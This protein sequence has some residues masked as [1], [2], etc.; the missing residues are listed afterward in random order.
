MMAN[1]LTPC[2]A[3]SSW[4]PVFANSAADTAAAP[5]YVIDPEMKVVSGLASVVGE[6]SGVA[7]V[8]S[9]DLAT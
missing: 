9:F 4:S 5:V 1:E 8:W 7:V 3:T 2:L 6:G